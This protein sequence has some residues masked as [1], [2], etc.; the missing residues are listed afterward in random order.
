MIQNNKKTMHKQ[1]GYCEK[2]NYTGWLEFAG[3]DE[4]LEYK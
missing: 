4:D 3:K 2:C 1:I